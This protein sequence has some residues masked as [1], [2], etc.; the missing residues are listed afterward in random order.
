MIDAGIGGFHGRIC[1]KDNT[2][3]NFTLDCQNHSTCRTVCPTDTITT[4]KAYPFCVTKPSTVILHIDDSCTNI[5][6]RS[7]SIWQTGP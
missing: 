7:I 2:S 4:C 5:R 3:F 1:S 6:G